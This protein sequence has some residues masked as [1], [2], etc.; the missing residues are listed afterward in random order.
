MPTTNYTTNDGRINEVKG[1][2]LAHAVQVEVLAL[3]CE[4]KKMPRKAGDNI[5]YRRWIPFGA[6]T[7]S[8]STQN[9]PAATASAHIIAEG[10]TPAA[11]TLTPV[12]VNMVQQQYACLY[13]YTDKAA[14]LYE[15]DIPGEM[16]EQA[17]ERMGLVR[18]MV[19][20]GAIKAASNVIYAGGT[21]RGTVDEA[22]SREVLG[23]MTR[24]LKSN[25]A[26][27]KTKILRPAA[28]YD[29]SAIRACYPVFA[30]TD[31]QQDLEDLSGFTPVEKYSKYDPISEHELGS[32]PDYRFILSPEL[33]SYADSGAAVGVTGL[34][35]TTGTNIDVYPY[36]LMG[37][38][39][40]TRVQPPSVW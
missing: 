36:L 25:H 40:E 37:E 3:G 4:M 26:M 12:D 31:C 28:E 38:P 21:T 17:G 18:E 15:D 33:S 39:E 9:R 29:T 1:E 11:D 35:S 14:E 23:R 27:K 8:V 20:Y 2:T 7:T 13:A 10:V 30:H 6:T 5:T 24:T 19:R 16:I 32:T 22:I 34:K